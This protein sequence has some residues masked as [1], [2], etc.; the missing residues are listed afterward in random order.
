MTGVCV[1]ASLGGEDERERGE[2][3]RRAFSCSAG[4]GEARGAVGPPRVS[5]SV[6][7][8]RDVRT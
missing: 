1:S 6:L 5:N 4:R 3:A 7:G 8:W 2:A